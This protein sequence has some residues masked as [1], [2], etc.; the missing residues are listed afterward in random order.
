LSLCYNHV[1]TW[2]G[3]K[4][5][6]NG[7]G[8]EGRP[9]HATEWR[10]AATERFKRDVG[11]EESYINGGDEESERLFNYGVLAPHADTTPVDIFTCWDAWMAGWGSRRVEQG[12]RPELIGHGKRLFVTQMV[13]SHRLSLQFT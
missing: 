11:W 12:R 8:Q 7:T 1:W 10:E 3:R 4:T 5:Q 13:R 6:A 2:Y 9:I